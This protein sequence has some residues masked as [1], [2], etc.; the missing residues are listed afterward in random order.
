MNLYPTLG[1]IYLDQECEILLIQKL[2]GYVS[3]DERGYNDHDLVLIYDHKYGKKFIPVRTGTDEYE[4]TYRMVVVHYNGSSF[5]LGGRTITPKE[6]LAV[7]ADALD[8]GIFENN[9]HYFV[10][11]IY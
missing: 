1:S 3:V 6:L 7:E 9:N 8:V 11:P 10:R 5:D 2:Y 4:E